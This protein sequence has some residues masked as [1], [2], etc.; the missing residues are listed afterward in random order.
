[1]GSR[2]EL[3]VGGVR[4]DSWK[5]G[6]DPFIMVLFS[7]S[8]KRCTR[9]PVPPEAEE[10]LE[11]G[12][13]WPFYQVQYVTTV[14]TLRKRLEF[15]GF[16]LD[17]TKRAFDIA[18]QQEIKDIQRSIKNWSERA[19]A[20][21]SFDSILARYR[22]GLELVS[23]AD[24]DSW[25]QG[26]QE[27]YRS[28]S[29]HYPD[30]IVTLADYFQP[31]RAFAHDRFPGS[32]DPRFRLRIEVE[33]VSAEEVL[34]DVSALVNDLEYPISFPWTEHA[35][36]E[37]PSYERQRCHII[38]LTEGSTDKFYLES[39]FALFH[40]ELAH[41]VSFL[42]FNGWNVPGGASFLE[43]MVRSFVAAGI[44]D[45][46][47]AVFDN[48][49]AG[50]ASYQRLAQLILPPNIRVLRYPDIELAK[51]YPTVG[52]SG[53]VTMD[54]NGL[55]ASIELYLGEDVLRD[56]NGE[57]IPV[58]WKSFD[59]SLKRYQGEILDKRGHWKRFSEKLAKVGDRPRSYEGTEWRDL[60]LVTNA[61]RAAFT[62]AD[63]EELISSVAE[64]SQ[65]EEPDTEPS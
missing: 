38:V 55:A 17:I 43:S 7:E 63:G 2:A 30:E 37:L 51:S 15:F 34:L 58:Q 22:R 28:P 44:R 27:A 62:M 41:Y 14:Q 59:P 35:I 31:L 56:E 16:T 29:D 49:T 61:L 25:I 13:E 33:A 9:Y 54:V 52:P 57:L 60:L 11:E 23:S 26:I 65:V 42:D 39:A 8:E 64:V 50:F 12:E 48:D 46:I 24:F 5:D 21:K 4:F 40:P 45:R 1:M 18:K 10:V 36:D 6:V 3:E 32:L 47:V 19:S 20:Q 53:T